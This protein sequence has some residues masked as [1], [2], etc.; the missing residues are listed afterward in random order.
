METLDIAP[1]MV[2][3]GALSLIVGFGTTIWNVF[4]SPARK[5]ASDIEAMQDVA[6]AIDRRLQKV[7]D[8]M[9][10]LP[11]RSGHS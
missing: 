4:S 2:W 3:I 5:N 7:E 6:A 1:L 9:G 11:G 8:I 10:V